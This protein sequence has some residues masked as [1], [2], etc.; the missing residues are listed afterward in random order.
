MHNSQFRIHKP[1][2]DSPLAVAVVT[3]LI[4][5]SALA[6]PAARVLTAQSAVSAQPGPRTFEVASVKTGLSPTES[7]RLRAAGRGSA[8]PNIFGIRTFPGGRLTANATLKA[9]IGRAYGV[10]D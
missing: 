1:G 7:G 3:A 4:A 2:S 10:K 9:L 6:R 8:A 5:V